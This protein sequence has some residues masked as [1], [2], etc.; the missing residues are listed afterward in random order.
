MGANRR[1][2]CEFGSWR[3]VLLTPTR[4]VLGLSWTLFYVYCLDKDRM[5]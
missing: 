2:V 3:T 1:M 4:S 5:A